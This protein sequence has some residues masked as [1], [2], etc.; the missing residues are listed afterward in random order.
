MSLPRCFENRLAGN[1]QPAPGADVQ[2]DVLVQGEARTGMDKDLTIS[3]YT[4]GPVA[5]ALL[6][7][8]RPGANGQFFHCGSGHFSFG[9][10]TAYNHALI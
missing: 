6:S 1:S 2:I 4:V 5:L 9:Y 7:R 8:T 10:A 3:P